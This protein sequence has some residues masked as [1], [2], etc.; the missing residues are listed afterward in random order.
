[1]TNIKNKIKHFL[2][3]YPILFSVFYRAQGKNLKLLFCN[4][5]ELVIEGYPRSANTWAV[6]FFEFFQK[7]RVDI[8]HHLHTESQLISAAKNSIPAIVLI[9][10][11]EDC[12]KS[13]LIRENMAN[14]KSALKRYKNFYN[15]L[16][17][18]K[19]WFVIAEFDE[20]TRDMPSIIAKCNSKFG[21]NFCVGEINDEVKK[22]I[23]QEI[24]SINNRLDSGVETHVARPSN[25]RNSLYKEMNLDECK[26]LLD[27]ALSTYRKFLSE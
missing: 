17:P 11:P 23:Y 5:T 22:L 12:I 18:Y 7:R 10:H 20:V 14:I 21:T 26:N 2:G 1:M 27:E 8:A 16:M 9:R 3:Q 13:L 19:N 24:D 25:Q 6:V 4:S 15:N